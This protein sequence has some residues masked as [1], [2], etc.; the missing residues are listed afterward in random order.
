MFLEVEMDQ[1]KNI[2]TKHLVNK[3]MNDKVIARIQFIDVL[4]DI[5]SMIHDLTLDEMDELMNKHTCLSRRV[6]TVI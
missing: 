4:N 1:Q 5:E 6:N 3:N 2:T